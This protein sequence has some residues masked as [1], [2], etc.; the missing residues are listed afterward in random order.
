MS[1]HY[2]YWRGVGEIEMFEELKARDDT[3]F[4]AQTPASPE[5]ADGDIFVAQCKSR[6]T[7]S[8]PA[9]VSGLHRVM[10]G[11]V[12]SAANGGFGSRAAVVGSPGERRLWHLYDPS[13]HLGGYG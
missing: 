1:C 11:N 5:E 7:C 3:A 12:S 13:G 6:S 8:A 9:R 4:N 2:P 10:G